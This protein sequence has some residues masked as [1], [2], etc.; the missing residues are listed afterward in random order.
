MDL[1]VA[2]LL[3][4]FLHLH[5]FNHFLF[6]Y[7]EQSNF[8]FAIG[9]LLI[10]TYLLYKKEESLE[11]LLFFIFGIFLSIN[12]Y[13]PALALAILA[14]VV[15]LISFF[16]K[17][18]Y[19]AIKFFAC[20][21]SLILLV[22]SFTYRADF[23]L[24]N[25]QNEIIFYIRELLFIMQH[26]LLQSKG[27]S[28]FSIIFTPAPVIAMAFCLHYLLLTP[29]LKKTLA[30]KISLLLL[31]VWTISVFFLSAIAHG[32][33]FY[34]LDFR[35]HRALVVMPIWLLLI[36]FALR[37]IQLS[38]KLL[39]VLLIFY[40]SLGI[41]YQRQYYETISDSQHWLIIKWLKRALPNTTSGQ[42]QIADSNP[43]IY[44]SLNDE[45]QYFYP[46]LKAQVVN[47]NFATACL[48]ESEFLLIDEHHVCWSQISKSHQ[49][50]VA[51]YNREGNS[52]YLLKFNEA[53]FSPL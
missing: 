12:A 9:L 50:I 42:L 8:P 28:F 46:T 29:N 34:S 53:G 6:I 48:A 15:L 52:Y 17:D 43:A 21:L 11:Y 41:L 40:F 36:Y 24:A 5:F 14:L 23:K 4:F 1:Q 51:V 32:Y 18:R 25:Q 37:R 39:L 20:L 3:S 16:K 7:F 30:T 49:H 26:L 35:M 13:T 45:M 47:E 27:V 44:L 31:I 38:N 10:G 2:L 33:A 19:L 22:A